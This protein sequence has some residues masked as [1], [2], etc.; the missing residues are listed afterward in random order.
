[1]LSAMGADNVQK[2][3]NA[4]PTRYELDTWYHVDM[5]YDSVAG[6]V[7]VDITQEGSP[8]ASL[9]VTDIGQMASD[10]QFLGSSNV[11]DGGFQVP[12][13]QGT[14]EFDNVSFTGTVVPLPSAVWLGAIGLGLVGWVKRRKHKR[15]AAL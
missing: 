8:H 11:R 2:G 1:M 15:E 6:D 12:G 5:Q 10:L 13:S 3:D 4:L 7:M 14:A 9:S